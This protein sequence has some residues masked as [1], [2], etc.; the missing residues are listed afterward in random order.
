MMY[1]MCESK[2]IVSNVCAEI[3]A[4]TGLGSGSV[5]GQGLKVDPNDI[6][7]PATYISSLPNVDVLIS[8]SPL[9][10]ADETVLIRLFFTGSGKL[11][12]KFDE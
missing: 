1:D 5:S 8:E 12:L 4:D 10:S 7:V 11:L 2:Y 3:K 9:L 6:L